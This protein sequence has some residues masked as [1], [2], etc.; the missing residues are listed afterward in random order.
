MSVQAT[1]KNHL[2]MASVTIRAGAYEQAL[3]ELRCALRLANA[4]SRNDLKSRIFV[5]MNAI[6]P[7]VH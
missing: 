3:H 2:E 4:S 7:L 5:A 1:I 6:R